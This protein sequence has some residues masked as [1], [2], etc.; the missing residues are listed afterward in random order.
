M[1]ILIADDDQTS[2][3]IL[4]AVLKKLGHEVLATADGLQ[5][6]DALQ[7][8]DAPRLAILDWMMPGLDGLEICRRRRATQTT[9]PPYLVLLTSR[10]SREDVVAGLDAGADDYLAKPFAPEELR[11]RLQ[12]GQRI[13]ELQDTV[14]AQAAQ[15]S[16]TLAELKTLQS[17]VPVCAHCHRVSTDE[18]LW[19][20]LASYVET[21]PEAEF[22]PGSCPDCQ[23]DG[24]EHGTP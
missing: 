11:V 10:S 17:L 15:L 24:R 2:R 12:V 14:T 19:R 21:H 20:R 18:G 9:A 23:A 6:W 16:G 5:A 7:Q 3:S 22:T 1:R 8:P 13:V 4:T